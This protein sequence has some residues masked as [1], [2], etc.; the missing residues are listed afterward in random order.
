MQSE[1]LP[2]DR[3]VSVVIPA[4][5]EQEAVEKAVADVKAV[6]ANCDADWEII[7]VDDGSTDATAERAE[8]AG[9][10]LIS[11]PENRG[12]GA[13]LKT[14]IA[15]ARHERIVI[16]D[17]DGTYP[18]DA[19]PEL[20]AHADGYDM[21]VGARVGE[22][23][24]VPLLRRPAKWL[25]GH[26]A[27][28]LAGRSIPD[29]N[30]GLR[31]ID[32]ALVERFEHVLPSGFSFTTTITL[33]ALCNDRLVFYHPIEYYERVGESKIRPTHAF[34]FLLLV[35][36]AAVYF[37]PL[38]V[39][40][41]LGAIFF[42]GGFAKFVYDLVIGNLSETALLG[43]LGAALLWAVGLLSDQIARVGLSGSK[44]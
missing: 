6:L 43:F 42:L 26:L 15:N 7:V 32:R 44:R 14:G 37:N 41:P 21:V 3:G 24:A 18:A 39:F 28:Y 36:R 20:L 35:L 34:E 17:A 33:A 11:L 8:R 10:R 30:S 1:S 19:L 16:T 9:A 13:A 23:V 29:L 12:Y 5:N 4:F 38:K 27:S 40:L 2:R 22:N 31:V 25:L